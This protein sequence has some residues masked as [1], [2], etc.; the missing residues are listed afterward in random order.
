MDPFAIL[1]RMSDRLEPFPVR[2]N[3]AKD[4]RSLCSPVTFRPFER[5]P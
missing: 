4:F 5:T 2:R 3:R 1:R